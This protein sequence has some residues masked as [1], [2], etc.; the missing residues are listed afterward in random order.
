MEIHSM[1]VAQA[2]SRV[3]GLGAGGHAKVLIEILQA[4]G[5]MEITGL[6]DVDPKLW[7]TKLL[8]I[9]VLGSDELLPKLFVHG[10]RHVFIGV[11]TTGRSNRRR[12]LFVKA[13]NL[14]FVVIPCIH[15]SAV[16]SPSAIFGEGPNVMAGAVVNSSARIGSNVIV[17]TGAIVEHDCILEDH[18][19]V[20]PGARLASAV[21]VGEGAH[22]GIGASV[23]QCIRIGRNS[24][25][26][27]GAAVVS[28]VPDDTIVVGVPARPLR[29]VKA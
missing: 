22:V 3:I 6:L 5:A 17:N 23:R 9:V 20:A 16:I 21:T 29:K 27:A 13:H 14:G 26:G 28:D 7:K 11:G 15:P 18:S 19:H 24:V 25:V 10:I 2:S 1:A 4:M 8:G 12:K